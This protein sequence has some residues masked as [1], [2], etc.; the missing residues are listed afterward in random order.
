MSSQE[1]LLHFLEKHSDA[2]IFVCVYTKAQLISLCM[3]YEVRFKQLDTKKVLATT[4]VETLKKARSI[5]FTAPVDDRQFEV[6]QTINDEPDGRL[7]MRFRLTGNYE[8]IYL[9]LFWK[10]TILHTRMV[11]WF[12]QPPSLPDGTSRS[13][14]PCNKNLVFEIPVPLGI[15]SNH[16]RLVYG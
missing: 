5:P 9:E 12:E 15:S 8:L 2:S 7:L 13:Y 14:F 3:A 11:F 1:R 10:I 16:L 4:L 6:V